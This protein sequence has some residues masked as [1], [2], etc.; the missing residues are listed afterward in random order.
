MHYYCKFIYFFDS[1]IDT[2]GI[3]M[4]RDIL[5]YNYISDVVIGIKG[6]LKREF[7]CTKL[8][9]KYVSTDNMTFSIA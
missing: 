9:L 4:L 1:L 5:K 6:T 7:L 3:Y 8:K 2:A